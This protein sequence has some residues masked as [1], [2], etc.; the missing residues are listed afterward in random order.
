MARAHAPRVP[1]TLQS[2]PYNLE[3][4]NSEPES[5]IRLHY[6]QFTVPRRPFWFAILAISAS[7]LNAADRQVSFSKDIQP[8]L[9]ASCWTCHGAALQLSQLDLRTRESAL[10]GGEHGTVLA[11]GKAE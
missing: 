2:V 3:S 9:Q 10:K 1:S 6:N 7:S 5:S 11:P 8:I 4:Q